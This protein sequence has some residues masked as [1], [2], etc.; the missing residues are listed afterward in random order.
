MMSRKKLR[1]QRTETDNLISNLRGEVGE[2]LFTWILMKDLLAETGKY[3]FPN[4]IEN[5][6]N[7]RLNRLHILVDKLRDEMV[8]R[9]SELAERKIGRLN[10]YFAG[11]K[12]NKLSKEIKDYEKFIKKNNFRKKRNY[13]ISHKELPEKWKE[14]KSIRIPYEKVV[15]G[16]VKAIRLTKKIDDISLGPS[17]KYLWREMRKSRYKPIFP[18]KVSYMLMP[19][20]RLSKNDRAKIINEEIKKGKK[21]W[22]SID[23][24]VNGQKKK[25][26]ACK[27][28]GAIIIGNRVLILPEYPLIDIKNIE[29]S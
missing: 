21:V 1:E 26:M 15:K 23:A 14:H 20:F 10:F 24:V 9:L 18:P 29:I 16:I 28:W 17:A 6:D 5:M 19:Y 11:K 7:P 4:V 2:I 22:K 27:K 13:D 8:S 3:K 25:I 12:L